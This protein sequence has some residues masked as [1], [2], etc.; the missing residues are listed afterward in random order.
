MADRLPNP[1]TVRAGQGAVDARHS[2]S[3]YISMPT[4]RTHLAQLF[5]KTNTARQG[6]LISLLLSVVAASY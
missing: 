6:E 4:A 5:R 3:S 2:A 1:L